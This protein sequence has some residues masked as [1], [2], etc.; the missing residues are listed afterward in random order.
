M[1]LLET[2]LEKSSIPDIFVEAHRHRT[3]GTI[4]VY[5]RPSIKRAPGGFYVTQGML[6]LIRKS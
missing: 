6:L 3:T 4:I 5:M 2:G 1:W